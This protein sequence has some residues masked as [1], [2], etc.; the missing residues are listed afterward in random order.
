MAAL[1]WTVMALLVASVYGDAASFCSESPPGH[2]CSNDLTG[3]YWCLPSPYSSAFFE[4]PAGTQ[5]DCFVGPACENVPTIGTY[6]PCGY[7]TTTPSY[8][9]AYTETEIITGEN[10]Y[11]VYHESITGTATIYL[12]GQ[13]ERIDTHLATNN[14]ITGV[15]V[16]SNTETFYL[17]GYQY[18]YYPDFN[19][20]SKTTFSGPLPNTGVPDGYQILSSNANSDTYYFLTGYTYPSEPYGTTDEITVTKSHPIHP[21]S[22]S[23]VV[24][25]FRV[26]YTTNT[27]TTSFH[28]GAPANSVFDL[29]AACI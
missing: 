21:I 13:M 15:V 2:Y 24:N 22:T 23:T 19:N 4:C 27:Y 7:H 5:C 14:S 10:S 12:N 16:Q 1:M 25:S 9:S 6:S 8:P 11:P 28:Q 3:F 17:N 18:V 20:C 26:T 29:P